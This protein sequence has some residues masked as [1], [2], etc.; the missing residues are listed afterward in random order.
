MPKDRWDLAEAPDAVRP[1]PNDL[2]SPTEQARRDLV[3]RASVSVVGDQEDSM[4][5][6]LVKDVRPFHRRLLRY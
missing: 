6:R 2:P 4:V 5:G 3:E 1:Y